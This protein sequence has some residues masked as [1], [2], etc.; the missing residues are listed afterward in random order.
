MPYQNHIRVEGLPPHKK[1]LF[2]DKVDKTSTCWL[3]TGAM[4]KG[5]G[6]FNTGNGTKE[7]HRI[8]YQMLVGSIPSGLVIDHLCR[9]R[10]C[11]NPDHL[12]VVT[13]RENVSRGFQA[14]KRNKLPTGVRWKRG[15]YEVQKRFGDIRVYVS[16]FDDIESARVAYETTILGDY[17]WVK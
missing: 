13:N 17:R 1:R 7:V 16:R 14:I 8:A 15:K 9:V 12:E 5:Y 2:W 4:N 10:N 3:W 6:V 11:I